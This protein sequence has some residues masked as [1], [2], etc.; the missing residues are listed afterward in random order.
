MALQDYQA[1]VTTP[2]EELS[3]TRMHRFIR[4]FFAYK[5]ESDYP[6]NK[7][8]FISLCKPTSGSIFGVSSPPFDP[9]GFSGSANIVPLRTS[10]TGS[11]RDSTSG[12]PDNGALIPGTLAELSTF[13]AIGYQKVEPATTDADATKF[14]AFVPSQKFQLQQ[15]YINKESPSNDLY[16]DPTNAGDYSV[17]ADLL[18]FIS[19]S[20]MMSLCTDDNPSLLVEL[21]KN[22]QLPGG[23]GDKEF[24][25]VP[26]NLHPFIK[27]NLAYFLTKG[28]VNVGGDTSNLIELDL[29]NYYLDQ[30][31]KK[32]NLNPAPI[33]PQIKAAK[34]AAL[35]ADK[36]RFELPKEEPRRKIIPNGRPQEDELTRRE[37]RQERRNERRE[38]RQER[39]NERRENRYDRREERQNRRRNRRN[40]R[41]NR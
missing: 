26:E 39:R 16:S 11:Y 10:L 4:Q 6:H 28:G 21:N 1:P 35:E 13:E 29:T 7:R 9:P 25:V 17:K 40:R 27:D 23:I 5:E 19:G 41:R 3:G 38:D 8:L 32:P 14:F 31:N 33:T 2:S 34:R 37:R 12:D 36:R 22:Q 30:P 15:D 18:N 24:V 20:Y